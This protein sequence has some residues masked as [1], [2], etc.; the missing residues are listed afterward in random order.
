[1]LSIRRHFRTFVETSMVGPSS[2]AGVLMA[3]S[4]IGMLHAKKWAPT[5]QIWFAM[6]LLRSFQSSISMSGTDG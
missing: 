3:N 4:F 5:Q 2:P 6:G 1:M